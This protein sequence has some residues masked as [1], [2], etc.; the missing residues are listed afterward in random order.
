MRLVLE[1]AGMQLQVSFVL[2]GGFWVEDIV[3]RKEM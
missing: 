1:D 2:M 3:H